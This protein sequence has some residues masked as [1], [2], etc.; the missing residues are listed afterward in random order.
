MVRVRPNL[1][2]PHSP[3]WTFSPS[4]SR[5]L[6]GHDARRV[7]HDGPTSP[8][9]PSEFDNL[10][11]PANSTPFELAEFYR[12]VRRPWGEFVN[13]AAL[14]AALAGTSGK[15]QRVETP[16][17]GSTLYVPNDEKTHPA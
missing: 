13:K 12:G 14:D 5:V 16:F 6:T 9:P 15:V 2:V 8:F 3:P 17:R 1:W 7:T 10:R 4:A 11:P